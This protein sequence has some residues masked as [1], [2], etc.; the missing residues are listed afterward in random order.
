MYQYQDMRW[1]CIYPF[2]LRS[3]YQDMRWSCIYPFLLRS[4][5]QD[6]RWSCICCVRSINYFLI[7]LG[8]WIHHNKAQWFESESRIF[9]TAVLNNV[10]KYIIEYFNMVIVMYI[11]YLSFFSWGFGSN[12]KNGNNSRTLHCNIYYIFI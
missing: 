12:A 7:L 8:G 6:M 4:Q 1:S 10:M 3:Q 2:L 9:L 5:Y 11:T